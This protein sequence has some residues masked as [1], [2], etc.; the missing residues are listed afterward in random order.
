M[1]ENVDKKEKTKITVGNDEFCSNCME[2]QEYDDE[3][4]CKVCGRYIKK[5]KNKSETAKYDDYGIDSD[6]FEESDGDVYF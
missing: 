4:K 5:T 2:W 6:T 3:G 1:A